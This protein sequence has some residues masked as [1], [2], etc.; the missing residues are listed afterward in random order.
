MKDPRRLFTK[1]QKAEIFLRAEG[2]CELCERKLGPDEPWV[3]G[4]ELAHGLGGKTNVENGRVECVKC[5]KGT[6]AKDHAVC[7]K[8]DRQGGRKGQQARRAK[9]GSRLQSRGFDKTLRKKMNGE[10]VPRNQ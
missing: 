7:A 1:K 3:A 5:S 8:A 9:N 10:V 2:H 4:H 6:A